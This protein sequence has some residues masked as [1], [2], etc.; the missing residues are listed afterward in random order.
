MRSQAT[1]IVSEAQRAEL[2]AWIRRGCT[3]QKQVLRARM[4]LMSADGVPT[5]EIVRRLGTTVPTLSRWRR[6]YAEAGIDGLKKDKPRKPG[7]PPVPQAK[8]R[9]V[10]ALT[11][12]PPPDGAD[13]WTCRG[14]ARETGLSTST[15]HAIW[16]A[17][18][19][20]RHRPVRV[21]PPAAAP[22]VSADD[23]AFLEFLERL[24][25]ENACGVDLHL[26]VGD[27]DACGHPAV[28]DWLERHPHIHVHAAFA[29]EAD[30][31]L[32]KPAS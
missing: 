25:R 26:I 13:H 22:G 6:R 16:K 5:G 7:K 23:N 32:V 20:V 24:D 4:I 18:G 3:P 2:E 21:V 1:L 30:P 29:T 31:V 17:A 14:M 28:G 10:L 15:I 27:K 11:M 19:I 9:Q 12:Q 8:V